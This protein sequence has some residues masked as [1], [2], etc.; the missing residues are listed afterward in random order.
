MLAETDGEAHAGLSG[1]AQ[2]F[3]M[4]G[5]QGLGAR[6]E[7]S[8]FRRHPHMPRRPFQQAAT[9]PCLKLPQTLADYGLDRACG[10]GGTGQVSEPGDQ[11]KETHRDEIEHD[12]ESL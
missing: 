3:L 2:R 7:C 4:C 1:G 8:T 6:Q 9:K 11:K 5:K 10:L 12:S